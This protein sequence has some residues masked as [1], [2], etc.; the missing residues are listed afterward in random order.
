MSKPSL[1]RETAE[2]KSFKGG[3]KH[4]WD[5]GFYKGGS[6]ELDRATGA[7]VQSEA[8]PLLGQQAMY[9][10][11]LK[12]IGGAGEEI[13]AVLNEAD[14]LARAAGVVRNPRDLRNASE[15]V[16]ETIAAGGEIGG[17]SALK[18]IGWSKADDEAINATLGKWRKTS[19]ISAKEAQRYDKL[20]IEIAEDV[21]R[22][23]TLNDLHGIRMGLDKRIGGENF[24]KMSN[25]DIELVKQIRG[26]VSEKIQAGFEG[27]SAAGVIQNTDKW[28]RVNK[29]Y[30][31]LSEIMPPLDWQAA[32]AESNVN[33]GGLRWRDLL[34]T[35]TGS[36]FGAAAFGPVGAVAGGSLGIANRMLQTDTGLLMRA[37]MGERLQA[38]GWLQK[39]TEAA[40]KGIGK[41]VAS[42][43]RGA[44][45]A[46]VGAAITR[47]PRI[48][49]LTAIARDLPAPITDAKARAESDAEWFEK[50][51][52]ELL[53][54]AADP[55]IAAEKMGDDLALLSAQAPK[56]AD[57]VVTKWLAVNDYLIR[58]MPKN[59]GSPM[60]I[61]APQWKPADYE[62][63]RFRDVVRVARQPL[64]I[65]G[66][67]K[68]GTVTRAQTAAVQTLYPSLYQTMFDQV[69]DAVTK[70][71]VSLPYEKRLQLG[72]LFPGVE[73]SM[74]PG[75]ATR[76]N[77]T[78]TQ[79]EEPPPK[80]GYRP[81]GAA[82]SAK[83]SRHQTNV[84]RLSTR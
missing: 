61:L 5:E 44:D 35:A 77:T 39:T 40:E 8:G 16:Y 65:L 78:P 84:D 53:T 45:A 80:Q 68:A 6:V 54:I 73:A 76:M 46:A 20:A 23:A 74:V 42:F 3:V 47:T 11:A 18:A 51:Q 50:T 24:K 38:L 49:E 15:R 7:L 63:S 27:L 31:S 17:E 33:V 13:G 30:H 19:Q 55:Q 43:I 10:R 66:D 36:S 1:F 62:I 25:E 4:L 28:K 57:A 48:G 12:I 2:G 83:G 21:N 59:P 32:R 82:K 34:A 79:P 64:S 9:D 75:F 69:R 52:A 58:Q 67:I 22:S 72:T 14:D 56:T 81:A 60:N 41:S 29:L 71:G 26:I 70:P 37:Q